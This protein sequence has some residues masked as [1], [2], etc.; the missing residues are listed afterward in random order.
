L[1]RFLALWNLNEK[2]SS[3]VQIA[4]CLSSEERVLRKGWHVQLGIFI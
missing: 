4:Y 2:L 1:I 3:G